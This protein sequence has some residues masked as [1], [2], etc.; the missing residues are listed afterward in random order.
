MGTFELEHVKFIFG[1]FGAPFQNLARA[2]NISSHLSS[3]VVTNH[4][5]NVNKF[6]VFSLECTWAILTS[7]V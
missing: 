3:C 5:A 7:N 6:K 2:Q 1:S 4:R